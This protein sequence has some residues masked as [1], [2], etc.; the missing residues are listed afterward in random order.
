MPSKNND[1]QQATSDFN[2]SKGFK[3][4]ATRAKKYLLDNALLYVMKK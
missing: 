3:Q 2:Y 1:K 4:G